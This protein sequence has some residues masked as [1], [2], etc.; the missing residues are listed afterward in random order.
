M[1]RDARVTASISIAGVVA[2]TLYAAWAAVQILVLNP[3][4]VVPG[5]SLAEIHAEMEA[6]GERMNIVLPLVVLGLGVVIAVIVARAAIGSRMAPLGAT[7]LF[8]TVLGFGAPAYFV[9]SF[10]TGMNLADAYNVSGGDQS[11]WAIPLYL[12]STLSFLG[13]IVVTVRHSRARRGP[14]VASAR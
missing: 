10:G 9:A 8:L 6:V 2:V 12:V 3:M 5:R 14:T 4:A 7:Q 13:V 1:N 11:P